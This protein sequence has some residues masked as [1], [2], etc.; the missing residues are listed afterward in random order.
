MAIVASFASVFLLNAMIGSPLEHLVAP[1]PFLAYLA[2][3]VGGVAWMFLVQLMVS[4]LLHLWWWR[5]E[6]DDRP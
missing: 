1:L 5:A 6:Q 4:G 3:L 2:I